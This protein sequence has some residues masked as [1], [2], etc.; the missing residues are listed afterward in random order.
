MAEPLYDID[1]LQLAPGQPGMT[2]DELLQA[3]RARDAQT[4]AEHGGDPAAANRALGLEN[5]A[6]KMQDQQIT[7]NALRDGNAAQQIHDDVLAMDPDDRAVLYPTAA[8]NDD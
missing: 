1:G 8:E 3:W 7:N 2:K 4:L 6:A 5:L